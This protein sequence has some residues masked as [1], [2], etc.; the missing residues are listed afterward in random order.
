MLN[1][2]FAGISFKVMKIFQPSSKTCFLKNKQSIKVTL[3]FKL[4][5]TWT[6][7]N[8]FRLSSKMFPFLI[9]AGLKFNWLLSSY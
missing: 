1:R 7:S 8:K 5:K 3:S 4:Y 2:F 9:S 6:C